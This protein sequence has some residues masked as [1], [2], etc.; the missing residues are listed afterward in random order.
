MAADPA[1]ASFVGKALTGAGVV[2]FITGDYGVAFGAFSGAVFYVTTAT[3]LPFHKKAGYF[4]FSFLTGVI[5]S[6]VVGAKLAQW[7]N[8]SDRPLNALGAVILSVVAVNVM[9][10]INKQMENPGSFLS[11]FRGGTNGK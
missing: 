1:T 2:G 4:I 3:D 8:Y 10:F 6:D 5:G 7:L 11:R 9:T